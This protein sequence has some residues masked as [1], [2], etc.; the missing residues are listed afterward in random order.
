MVVC[1]T[2][3]FSRI[4]ENI[5][6][7]RNDEL[8]KDV[9]SAEILALYDEDTVAVG[10]SRSDGITLLDADTGEKKRCI[11][12]K[13]INNE[14]RFCFSNDS[15]F[16]SS[17]DQITCYD[18]DSGKVRYSR[19]LINVQHYV[20][21]YHFSSPMSMAVGASNKI[22]LTSKVTNSVFEYDPVYKRITQFIGQHNDP[23]GIAVDGDNHLH[24]CCLRSVKVLEIKHQNLNHLSRYALN[25]GITFDSPS[26]IAI[27]PS[28]F[29]FVVTSDDT[30]WVHGSENQRLYSVVIQ[31]RRILDILV[32][33]NGMLWISYV[34]SAVERRIELV[35]LPFSL[36]FNPPPPLSLFCQSAI[37][38]NLATLPASLLPP[39]YLKHVDS[40][41]KIVEVVVAVPNMDYRSF[42]VRVKPSMSHIDVMEYLLDSTIVP[43]VPGMNKRIAVEESYDSSK[44]KY[45]I[46]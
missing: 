38:V 32:T 26:K 2:H 3:S 37:L 39:K 14:K 20:G 40:W 22:Y 42:N 16:V 33:A 13:N 44:T 15:L 18:V 17:R 6:I 28:G 7:Y 9:S 1:R 4:I 36:A 43:L 31:S 8:V 11:P 19:S 10:G 12:V 46:K 30:I 5:I 25:D 23:S 24:V 27:H 41:S 21:G 35:R 29:K 45:V 34:N